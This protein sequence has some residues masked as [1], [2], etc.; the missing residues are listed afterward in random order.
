MDE[1]IERLSTGQHRVS[2]ATYKSAAELKKAIDNGHV[3]LKFTETQGGTELGG[4]LDKNRCVLK[5]ADFEAGTGSI[6]LVTTLVLNYNEVEF[7]ADVDLGTLQG[8]GCLKLIAD[9]PA[10]RAKQAQESARE[11]RV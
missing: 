1:L 5:D 7:I 11:S 10:W 2:A 4:R 9:E 8:Q 6:Q 3:L